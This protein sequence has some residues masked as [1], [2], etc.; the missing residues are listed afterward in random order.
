MEE[1]LLFSSGWAAAFGAI[2]GLASAHDHVVL[3]EHAHS[4]LVEGAVVS[5]RNVS[6]FQHLSVDSLEERLRGIR[7]TT[8]HAGILVAT[9]SLFGD[10]IT[11]DVHGVLHACRQFGATLLV[12]VALDIGAMGPDGTGILGNLGMASEV[13]MVVGSFSHTLCSSGGFVAVKSRP[14]AE[15]LKYNTSCY[16]DSPGLSPVQAAVVLEA[17]RIVRSPEG[18]ARRQ[19]LRIAART[20]RE[21]AARHDL[22]VSGE[23][24]PIV[25]IRIRDELL[26]RTASRLIAERGILVNLIEY[27]L[28]AAG[29]A[30]FRLHV[31]ADHDLIHLEDA[32]NTIAEA[33]DDARGHCGA[34]HRGL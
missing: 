7:M 29:D 16:R 12:D 28:A 1:C 34:D 25:P 21:A 22:E 4:G 23:L 19:A 13:D 2:S 15:F 17:L 10:S 6:R 32:M 8:P 5:T 26:A 27:P 30:H 9:Q 14:A 18:E 11:S 33:I 3:D 20:T 24:S 31:M